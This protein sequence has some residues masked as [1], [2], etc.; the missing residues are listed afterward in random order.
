MGAVIGR[1][2]DTIRQTSSG[3]GARVQVSGEAM[4]GSSEKT[5]AISGSKDQI[6]AALQLVVEQ[7]KSNPPKQG[8]K[9]TPYVPGAAFAPQGGYGGG[10]GGGGGGGYG[11]GYGQQ[12]QQQQYGGGGG[13]PGFSQP[14]SSC[15]RLSASI[16]ALSPSDWSLPLVCAC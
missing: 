10:G 16:G 11:G 4:P 12:Q 7:I 2:G 15:S 14:T 3:T 5:V 13:A 6:N 9:V 1:G 8:T